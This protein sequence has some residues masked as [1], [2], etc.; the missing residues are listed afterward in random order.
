[1]HSSFLN[2]VVN[3][4][5]KELKKSIQKVREVVRYIRNSPSRLRKFKEIASYLKI[6]SKISN[7]IYNNATQTGGGSLF[8]CNAGCSPFGK[9]SPI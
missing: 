4:G 8:S 9:V 7:S 5:M 6:T 2:L 3:D 1:M